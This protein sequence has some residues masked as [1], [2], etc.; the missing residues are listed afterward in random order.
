MAIVD[1]AEIVQDLSHRTPSPFNH[2]LVLEAFNTV[3]RGMVDL[4]S[5]Q[6]SLDSGQNPENATWSRRP[7][8]RSAAEPP[9]GSGGGRST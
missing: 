5:M 6:A 2:V 1:P 9:P 3:C 8:S 4:N 7:A